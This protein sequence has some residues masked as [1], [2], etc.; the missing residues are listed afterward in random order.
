[1]LVANRQWES[2]LSFTVISF[3]QGLKETVNKAE[4][5]VQ[6]YKQENISPSKTR[7]AYREARDA[8]LKQWINNNLKSA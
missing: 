4:V 7:T 3:G 5:I 1:M 6:I 2:E 8:V